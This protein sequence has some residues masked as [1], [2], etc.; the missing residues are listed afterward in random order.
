M[1]SWHALTVTSR[2]SV[3]SLQHPLARA[4]PLISR[5]Q[6][7]IYT[8]LK[9][10][11][12]GRLGETQRIECLSEKRPNVT[13]DW[14]F[15]FG[16]LNAQS[17]LSKVLVRRWWRKSDCGGCLVGE[18]LSIVNQRACHRVWVGEIKWGVCGTQGELFVGD[19]GGGIGGTNSLERAGGRK[20]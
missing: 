17:L 14:Y 1:K 8:G 5:G 7:V 4:L 18:G 3:G 19:E 11:R 20:K 13:Q 9:T 10:S 15:W 2:A 6:P 16:I 12:C